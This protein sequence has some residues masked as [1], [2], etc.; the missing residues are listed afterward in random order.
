M[1]I[2]HAI[3]YVKTLELGRPK[4]VFAGDRI[5]QIGPDRVR[6]I[7]EDESINPDR[8]AFRRNARTVEIGTPIDAFF[9]MQEQYTAPS[10][11]TGDRQISCRDL[12][13]RQCRRYTALLNCIPG[14]TRVAFATCECCQDA[15]TGARECTCERAAPVLPP[16]GPP[17][18]PG[19]M[20]GPVPVGAIGT[21]VISQD[22]A[23]GGGTLRTVLILVGIL[24]VGYFLYTRYG[25]KAIAAAT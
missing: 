9:G 15:P 5:I 18:G 14:C 20:P 8:F 6:D 4:D 16:P 7:T 22:G 13:S 25:K 17:S 21:R 11:A 10:C 2:T 3:P 12:T 23:P 24:A 19:F 1:A